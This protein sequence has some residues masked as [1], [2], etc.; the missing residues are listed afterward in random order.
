MK[1][2]EALEFDPRVFRRRQGTPDPDG[3]CI[4]YWMQRSQR[5][6]DNPALNVAI[7]AGNLLGKPVLV[8]FQLLHR[9]HHAN[10]RH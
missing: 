10:L 2:F 7:Q 9:A 8:F 1:K 3:R 5:A 6:H 4:V